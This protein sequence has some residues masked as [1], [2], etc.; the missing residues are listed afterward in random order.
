LLEF[1]FGEQLHGGGNLFSKE[2]ASLK[3]PK[4]KVTNY[5]ALNTKNS[6]GETTSHSFSVHV[7]FTVMQSIFS[8]KL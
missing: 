8:F 1:I 3:Y 2:R 4:I 7:V 6:L 5:K